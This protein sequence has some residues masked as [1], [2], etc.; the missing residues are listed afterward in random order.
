MKALNCVMNRCATHTISANGTCSFTA[1]Q[2]VALRGPERV[3][4]GSIGTVLVLV[5]NGHPS[6]IRSARVVPLRDNATTAGVNAELLQLADIRS[7]S[8]H[9]QFAG[10]VFG[11]HHPPDIIQ[12]R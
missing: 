2:P 11:F 5:T 7:R 3:V 1:S 9:L 6:Q 4:A 12:Y 8:E 10:A